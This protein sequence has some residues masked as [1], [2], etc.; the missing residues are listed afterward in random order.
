MASS[1]EPLLVRAESFVA[2]GNGVGPLY[3]VPAGR[4]AIFYIRAGSTNAINTSSSTMRAAGGI[5]A[6]DTT[7]NGSGEAVDTSILDPKPIRLD[8]G[9]TISHE[10]N[11][12]VG[13]SGY[14][15]D[16]FVEEYNKP[17]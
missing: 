15:L 9:E 16:G 5:I 8:E 6:Q 10:E 2:S 4:F 3:T 1:F 7:L 11:G 13:Q 12:G 17:T 14:V